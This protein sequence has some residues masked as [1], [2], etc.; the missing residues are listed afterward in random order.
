MKEC[1]WVLEYLRDLDADFIRFYQI[2]DFY[3]LPCDRFLDLANRVS[4]YQ[5]VMSLRVEAAQE[6]A[7]KHNPSKALR[8]G[9]GQE[10]PLDDVLSMDFS[11]PI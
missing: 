3:E 7:K 2:Y 6:E 5:G 4:A 9:T 10:V 8:D 1:I 11:Q